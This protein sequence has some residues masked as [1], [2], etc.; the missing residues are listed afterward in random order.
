MNKSR[1]KRCLWCILIALSYALLLGICYFAVLSAPYI[2][3]V[4]YLN[5]MSERAAREYAINPDLNSIELHSLGALVFDTDGN[6]IESELPKFLHYFGGDA[7]HAFEEWPLGALHRVFDGKTVRHVGFVLPK[8]VGV[9]YIGEPIYRQETII[10]AFFLIRDLH[11]L[12]PTLISICIAYSIFFV[13]AVVCLFYSLQKKQKY[14]HLQN[15]YVANFSHDLKSP[16][17]SIKALAE[18]L[19]AGLVKDDDTRHKYY[20][21][22]INEATNLQH[23]VAS[24]LELSSMQNRQNK[25]IKKSENLAYAM[26]PILEK[27][28][29]LCYDIMI[30]FHVSEELQKLPLVCTNAQSLARLVDILLDNS[31]KFVGKNGGVWVES[32]LKPNHVIICIRD[33]GCGISEEHQKH[34]FDRFFMGDPSHSGKGNGLGLAIAQEITNAL[35]EK[36]WVESA[37]GEGSSF[38]FTVHMK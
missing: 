26:A 1:K 32:V 12:F 19:H 7:E 33:N 29:M 9:I 6:C 30:D 38:C 18:T 22:I 10:G 37:L 15:N 2:S 4:D 20:S 25:V 17:T 3:H 8:N 23:T 24:I 14:L 36:L 27:Y 21:T 11:D 28:G 34:I 35:G 31:I 13:L 5:K 16:I